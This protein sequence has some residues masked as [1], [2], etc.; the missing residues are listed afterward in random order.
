MP[1]TR[2]FKP[3]DSK[4]LTADSNQPA[5]SGEQ[6]VVSPSGVDALVGEPVDEK[7][8][9]RSETASNFQHPT[10]NYRRDGYQNGDRYS[11][12]D[13][14]TEEVSGILDTMPEGHGFLRPKYTPSDRDVYI[15]SSQIRRFNLRPGDFVD[16]AARPPKE[17]ERYFGL[18]QVNK[19][20][21]EDAEKYVGDP[22]VRGGR[23][24]RIRFEDFTPIY[25]NRHL[26]LE[27]GKMPLS[28]RVIDLISPIGFGQRA[29]VVS[30]A[31]A[32][33]TTLLKDIAAGIS[34]N[35]PDVVLMAV[36]VGERP[37]EV[38]DLSRSIKGDVIASNFDEPAENQTTAAEI[39]LE[40]AKRLVEAGK[41]VVILLDSITRLGRAY[42][43]SVPPSGRTLSG[44]FDPVALYPPKHFFGAAR[45]CEE[46]GSLTIIGTALVDTGS[47]MDDL[48]YEE[49]KGTGNME[50]HLDR[51]L[52]ER[53]IYPAINIGSS[54]TRQE[55]LM[56]A[57]DIYRKMVVMRRMLGL[58][59]DSERTEVFLERLAKVGS[60]AEF[61]ESL[62]DVK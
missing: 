27:T 26:K 2:S 41:D 53:R 23:T 45:N 24:K 54:G 37:E 58:L 36:L 61:L 52:A 44:G 56:F 19:V 59:N 16:G 29:M 46:G 8:D 15:S 6:S 43:L 50:L 3:K 13:V 21:G 31:K 9:V 49:F 60:N 18:L 32:G 12:R 35:H 11:D 30:P 22:A 7:P 1:N 20:N 25:P 33:K 38:T 34:Q 17:N 39:A 47:R 5:V 4:Q 48:I 57:E 62:K 55:Q 51:F 10:S 40:R 28:Q 42:N 14:P